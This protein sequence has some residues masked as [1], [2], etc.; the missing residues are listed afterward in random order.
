MKKSE[1]L[2]LLKAKGT[3]GL[4]DSELEAVLGIEN[5]QVKELVA[6]YS[7]RVASHKA[8]L[9]KTKMSSSLDS[10]KVLKPMYEGL[11]VE[12]FKIILLRMDHSVIGVRTVSKGG[13]SGTLVDPKV[14]FGFALSVG[15]SAIILSHNHPSGNNKP[16][17]SDK[18]L[19]TKLKDGGKH[20]EI[21]ILD[22]I[23]IAGENYYSFAD[24]GRL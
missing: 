2:Q 9:I 22:H 21:S 10:F 17:D 3:Q 24:E 20:L 14:V 13:V 23:I 8:S 11:G 5:D 1:K 7:R 4:T 16:S 15:A 12:E 6:E 18:M 19:T